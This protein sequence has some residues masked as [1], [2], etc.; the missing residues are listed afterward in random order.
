MAAR[1]LGKEHANGRARLSV[2]GARREALSY[3]ISLDDSSGNTP[4][5]GILKAPS[6]LLYDA[7]NAGSVSL[8]L[9]NGAE[10]AIQV[11]SFNV[12]YAA[13]WLVD[14]VEDLFEIRSGRDEDAEED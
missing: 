9:S 13:F 4:G 5:S 6:N 10:L 14:S 12:D 8:L 2:D 11:T 1:K 3:A 7:L